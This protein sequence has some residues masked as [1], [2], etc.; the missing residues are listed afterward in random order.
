MLQMTQMDIIDTELAIEDHQ[1]WQNAHQTGRLRYFFPVLSEALPW[2]R[3]AACEEQQ[4]EAATS[5]TW[6]NEAH[7]EPPHGPDAKD[8]PAQVGTTVRG[9]GEKE[10]SQ[11]T[12][13]GEDNT[14]TSGH[15]YSLE[16]AIRDT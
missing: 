6:Y 14:K 4:E 11:E 8:C 10:N 5:Q 9:K 15:T 16:C 7:T 1:S 13:N 3:L 2:H 12:G